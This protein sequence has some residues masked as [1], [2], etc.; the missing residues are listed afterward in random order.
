MKAIMV[1]NMVVSLEQMKSAKIIKCNTKNYNIHIEYHSGEFTNVGYGT[2][3]E[4]KELLWNI[5]NRYTAE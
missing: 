3:N 2:E 1:N 4:M 5:Y